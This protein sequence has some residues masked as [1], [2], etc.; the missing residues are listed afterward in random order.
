MGAI[1]LGKTNMHEIGLGVTGLNLC[2]GTARNPY[3]LDHYCG[4]SSTGTGAVLA[5]GVCPIAIGGC[6]ISMNQGH[7]V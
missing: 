4:G 1:L 7:V 3:N 5:A 2:T 6:T